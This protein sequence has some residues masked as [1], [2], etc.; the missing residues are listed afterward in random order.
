MQYRPTT[1]G[2]DAV[3]AAEAMKTGAALRQGFQAGAAPGAAPAM[4]LQSMAGSVAAQQ[5]EGAVRGAARDLE[6]NQRQGENRLG[7]IQ[8]A[9]EKSAGERRLQLK[10][11]QQESDR[12]LS[13][14]NLQTEQHRFDEQL[15]FQRDELGRLAMNNVQLSDWVAL[16]AKNKE[17]FADRM[18]T[19]ELAYERRTKMLEMAQMKIRQVLEMES[20]GQIAAL[21]RETKELAI[22]HKIKQSKI[23]GKNQAARI[24]T[25]FE[26]GSK[27]LSSGML[28]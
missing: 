14:L 6:A 1:R 19:I 22:D 13:E 27:A 21:S 9:A 16:N 11:Q 28:A 8:L 12:E 24:G 5:G 20:K 23:D 4:D 2:G 15:S 26:I 7:G 10:Q 25:A 3:Q 17:E 18:Q